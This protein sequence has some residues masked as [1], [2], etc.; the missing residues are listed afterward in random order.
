MLMLENLTVGYDRH[1]AVH[2]LSGCFELGSLTAVVGPNGGGKSSL[3]KAIAGMV[4]PLSGKIRR[5]GQKIIGY[6]PQVSAIDRSFPM[7]VYDTVLL[8]YWP[9][10]RL[11]GGVS[12]A[13]RVA[14]LTALERVGMDSFA[15][16]PVA[17]LSTGQFQRILFARLMVQNA[18]I[19]LLDE[20]FNAIDSRTTHDLLAV[21]MEWHAAGKTVLAVLHDMEQVRS[22]FPQS[23]LLAREVIAWGATADVLCDDNLIRADRL[24]RQWHDHGDICHIGDGSVAA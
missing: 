14:A 23:L 17:A 10:C 5:Q 2:H 9:H 13:Q 6:L 16:R 21:V 15:S 8:G 11:L 22:F 18:D 24:A 4:S 3:L 12:A 7:S 20:P 19:I 1:P